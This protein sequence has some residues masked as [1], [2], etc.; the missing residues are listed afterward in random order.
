M[1]E[2]WLWVGEFQ[3]DEKGV[4]RLGWGIVGRRGGGNLLYWLPLALVVETD[5]DLVALLHVSYAV[6]PDPL[7]A[8]SLKD[9][10]RMRGVLV[11][12]G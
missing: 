10:G 7:P 4:V 5:L 6:G 8:V 1:G 11:L 3:G 2:G 12:T 9:F